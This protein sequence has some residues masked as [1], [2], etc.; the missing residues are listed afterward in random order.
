MSQL[1]APVTRLLLATNVTVV[2]FTYQLI[3]PSYILKCHFAQTNR[4]LEL[5]N[6]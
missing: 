3:T 4:I 5:Y 2:V 6:Y 1:D